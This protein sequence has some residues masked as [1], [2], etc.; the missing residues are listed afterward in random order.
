MTKTLHKDAF[1]HK[2]VQTNSV[3][4]NMF[5]TCFHE[6]RTY[7]NPQNCSRNFSCFL[8]KKDIEF[9]YWDQKCCWNYLFTQKKKKKTLQLCT[10]KENKTFSWK[11]M[12][13]HRFGIWMNSNQ[14]QVGAII[15]TV[16]YVDKLWNIHWTKMLQ[17]TPSFTELVPEQLGICRESCLESSLDCKTFWT[18]LILPPLGTTWKLIYNMYSGV[19]FWC[20]ENH[21]KNVILKC[22]LRHLTT[23]DNRAL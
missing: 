14:I 17:N 7:M 9:F 1:W 20:L 18:S 4:C 13:I 21:E 19:H 2:L 11:K 15:I 10:F 3:F 16:T 5:L 22:I 23:I 8:S 6:F 12:W